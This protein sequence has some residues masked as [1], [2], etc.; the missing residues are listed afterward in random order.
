LNFF[1]FTIAHK[2]CLSLNILNGTAYPGYDIIS[3]A[4]STYI[5]CCEW[6]FVT[7]TCVVFTVR[8]PEGGGGCFL[9][10]STAG[11]ISLCSYCISASI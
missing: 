1:Y 8:L 7:P 11:G 3:K 9:K 2:D 4:V 5:E 6:C 10:N